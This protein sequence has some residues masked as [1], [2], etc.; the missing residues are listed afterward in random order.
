MEFSLAFYCFSCYFIH[1]FTF[2][3]SVMGKKMISKSDEIE[4]AVY[5]ETLGRYLEIQ[6][7]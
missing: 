3:E 7:I 4:Q 6:M 1:K 5:I 2:L